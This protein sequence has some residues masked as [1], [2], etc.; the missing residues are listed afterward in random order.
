MAHSVATHLGL[1]LDEYDA[2][3]RRWIPGYERMLEVAADA[4]DAAGASHVL[5]LGAGTGALSAAVLAR[6]S[7]DVVELLD[8]DPEMMKRA[9]ARLAGHGERVRFTLRS[10]DEPFHPCD[11]FVASLSLHHIPTLE[12]KTVLFR[13]AFEALSAGGVLVNGDATMPEDESGRTDMFRYWADHQV[14]NGIA[15]DVAWAHFD[16]WAKEDHYLP[17]DE[18][19]AALRSVGF[20]AE[21]VWSAGPIGVVVARKA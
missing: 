1:D 14:K 8:V 7:A 9:R 21:Q 2:T 12:A 18:E 17:L 15:E 13:R 4:V 6:A 5:D 19:L 20:E 11:A 16:E 10:F 3:I